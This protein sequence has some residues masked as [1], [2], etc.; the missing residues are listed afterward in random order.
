MND[1][2]ETQH[3]ESKKMREKEME[4][5]SLSTVIRKLGVQRKL[6]RRDEEAGKMDGK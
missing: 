6:E 2:F 5:E 4:K 3:E 1:L